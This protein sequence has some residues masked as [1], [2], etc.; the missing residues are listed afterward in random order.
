MNCCLMQRY[1]H[2]LDLD[3]SMAAIV[4]AKPKLLGKRGVP[5]GIGTRVA[6]VKVRFAGLVSS[7]AD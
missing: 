5:D 2:Y 1:R 4:D 6:G 3:T 7:S